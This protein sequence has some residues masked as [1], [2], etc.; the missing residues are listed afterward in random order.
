MTK[1]LLACD[2]ETRGLGG[3]LLGLVF[4]GHYHPSS[5]PE[6][7]AFSKESALK[8]KER[9]QHDFFDAH[10]I[11]FH[12]AKYDLMILRREGFVINDYH[13]TMLMA[14]LLNPLM[15]CSL[16]ETAKRYLGKGKIEIEDKGHLEWTPETIEYCLKD[17]ELTYNL[18]LVLLKELEEDPKQLKWYLETELPFVE[19][20]LEMER[21]GLVIDRNRTIE[22]INE[23]EVK[24][25]N[26]LADVRAIAPLVPG[27][28]VIYKREDDP[29]FGY[30][31]KHGVLTWNHCKL[32]E[33]NPAS[34]DHIIHVLK[35]MGWEPE[36][37]TQ[38]GKPSTEADV[39]EELDYPIIK[40]ILVYK[41]YQKAIGTYLEAFLNYSEPLAGEYAVL[42]GNF[43]QCGTITGRL[44]SSQPNLQNIWTSGDIGSTIRSL[45][46]VPD[47]YDLISIDLSNI[48]ARTLA[49]YLSLVFGFTTLAHAFRD[50]LD[51]HQVNADTWQ[52]TRQ[53]A[54][55]LL[56]ALLYG[57]GPKKLSVQ[58]GVTVA[59]AKDAVAKVYDGMPIMQ[60]KESVWDVCRK[61]KGT[62]YTAM[63]RRL[64]Y[65]HINS[66]D[67]E[68]KA[69]A[70]RQVF[71]A[72]L[73]G[74]AAD[75][76]KVLTL[77]V[78]PTA[79]IMGAFL[80]GS[81]HDELLL[82]VPEAN[83]RGLADYLEQ[84]FQ[85]PLLSHCPIKGDAK[86]GKNWKEV[87]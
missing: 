58:M 28:E 85:R 15:P 51:F 86:I 38:S 81:I 3:E 8:N 74:S 23:Y 82:Y 76:L 20:I 19:A 53:Q 52:C 34:G 11:V 56:Y 42:Y 12:N 55:T 39:L 29:G 84:V 77:A 22:A 46:T 63:G 64:Y 25:E 54:K 62:I 60:L 83:S 6:S 13:D 45:V 73:Q 68:K 72:L 67:H 48:E 44:S 70:E 71:N 79:H 27:K 40:N 75:V 7:Y 21:I 5:D 50:G 17:T 49:H 35:S 78:L 69:R 14:H 4:Y 9:L 61:R 32:E 10:T 18:C 47:G 16:D 30:F 33:F 43:N 59:E 2:T 26:A 37:L 36:K 66:R 65:P 31:A 87:H 1:P 41:D 24:V 57:A 80:A